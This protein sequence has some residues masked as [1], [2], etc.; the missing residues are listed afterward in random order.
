MTAAGLLPQPT[1]TRAALDAFKLSSP[2]ECTPHPLAAAYD[3]DGAVL[4]LNELYQHA[5]AGDIGGDPRWAVALKFPA[6]ETVT[7]LL[8]IVVDVGRTGQVIP[9]ANLDVFAS[10]I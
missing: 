6:S 2:R 7:K 5:V 3:A 8:D 1:H 9:A 4:K 10:G